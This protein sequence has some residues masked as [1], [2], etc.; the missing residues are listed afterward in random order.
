MLL[1]AITAYSF[2]TSINETL[3]DY[4]K[5]YPLVRFAVPILLTCVLIYVSYRQKKRQMTATY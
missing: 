2:N 5:Q 3:E 1:F 4:R